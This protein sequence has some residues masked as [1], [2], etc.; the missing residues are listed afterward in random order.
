M[1]HRHGPPRGRA[2]AA[3]KKSRE[4]VSSERGIGDEDT[5]IQRATHPPSAPESRG[6]TA[7]SRKR[8]NGKP[9]SSASIASE[10]GASG[11]HAR[12]ITSSIEGG[13]KDVSM[14]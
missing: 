3:Q 6:G 8:K 14:P 11:L 12:K 13:G 7:R 10:E 2:R 4:S 9:I 5:Q 1:F